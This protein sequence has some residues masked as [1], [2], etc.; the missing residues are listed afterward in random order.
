MFNEG[1]DVPEVNVV[2]F[3]RSTSSET[4]FLQQLVSGLRKADGKSKVL[5]LDFAANCERI[6]MVR[7]LVRQVREHQEEAAT[8]TRRPY[9]DEVAATGPRTHLALSLDGV[10]FSEQAWQLVEL[11]EAVRA[12]IR[13]YTKEELI[14]QLQRKAKELG[15]TPTGL[16]ISADPR[17]AH[18]ATFRI[19]FGSYNQALVAAGL[20]ILRP[21]YTKKQLVAQLQR[22]TAELGRLPVGPDIQADPDMASWKTFFNVFGSYNLALEAA[23]FGAWEREAKYTRAELL[24]QLQHKAEELGRTPTMHDVDYDPDMASVT[25]YKKSFVTYS[26]AVMAAGLTPNRKTDASKLSPGQD[27][28]VI[29]PTIAAHTASTLLSQVLT[30]A[31]ALGRPPRASEVDAD[32]TMASAKEIKVALRASNWSEVVSHI[33]PYI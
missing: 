30:K 11:I 6:E 27:V 24:A 5:V 21:S 2:V 20:K 25:A 7:K 13:G 16:D 28:V 22:K 4:I 14:E 10:E 18:A 17:L 15:R 31:R 1:I 29:R 9:S 32:G 33:R 3:L 23:G 12:R 19:I 8:T 26:A